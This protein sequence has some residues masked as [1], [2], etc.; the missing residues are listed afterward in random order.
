[1][2]AAANTRA[3]ERQQRALEHGYRLAVENGIK[4]PEMADAVWELMIEAAA[5]LRRL[6]DRES[7][8]LRAADRSHWPEIVRRIAEQYEIAVERVKDG[9]D[10]YDAPR[11]RVRPDLQQ[12]DRMDVVFGW[13]SAMGAPGRKRRDIQ[14]VFDLANGV[15]VRII[16]MRHRCGRSTVYDIRNR[17]IEKICALLE[18]TAGHG[19]QS[20]QYVSA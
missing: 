19:A 12:I 10:P 18:K 1:M 2:I 14:V 20:G 16:R 13:M 6:P 11:A 4:Q 8:W 3:M 17:G 9:M 15:P 7:G 5:T